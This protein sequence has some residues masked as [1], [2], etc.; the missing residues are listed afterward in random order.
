MI[1]RS[2][3]IKYW[4][5][6]EIIRYKP[7]IEGFDDWDSISVNLGGDL[8]SFTIPKKEATMK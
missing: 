1:N 3:D 5:T 8:G 4:K 2:Y 7:K 6:G